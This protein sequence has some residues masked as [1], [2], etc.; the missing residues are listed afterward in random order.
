[1]RKVDEMKRICL[2][3]SDAAVEDAGKTLGRESA[4]HMLACV[5]R[6]GGGDSV[7]MIG[8]PGLQVNPL[9]PVFTVQVLCHLHVHWPLAIGSDLPSSK[10]HM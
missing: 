1:M 9:P 2:L 5:A 4:L 3:P 10:Q 6:G 7:A 8:G